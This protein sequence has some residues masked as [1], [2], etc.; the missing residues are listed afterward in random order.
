M[1]TWESIVL[2]L[3]GNAALLAVFAWLGRAVFAHFFA[4][5]LERFKS[6]L[7][8]A[9]SA[10]AE[11]MK[12]E[13]QIVSTEH[14]IRYVKLHERRAEVIEKLY[15]ML[16]EA[17]W[18][19]QSF[20]DVFEFAGE[21]PKAEKYLTAMNKGA[22]FFRFFDKNRIYLTPEVCRSLE[23]FLKGM[24]SHVIGFGVY[25][26]KD[27]KYFPEH[28]LKEKYAAWTKA[29]EYFEDELPAAREALE[30]EL[31]QLIGSSSLNHA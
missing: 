15:E 16:V 24:R 22:E 31:R 30:L 28:T 19:S 12:H 5:D 25:V 13:L 4:K 18:A 11:R 26:D 2:L 29:A 10:A 9:S 14:Q 3:G 7:S 8:H 23:N 27:E 6:D 17:H 21:P 1:Q 20:V